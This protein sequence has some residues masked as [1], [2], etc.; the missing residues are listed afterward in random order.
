VDFGYPCNGTSNNCFGNINYDNNTSNTGN[1]I[2]ITTDGT[3]NILLLLLMV[4][5]ND[6]V[7]SKSYTIII[8]NGSTSSTPSSTS[9]TISP[10][11]YQLL[12]GNPNNLY[13]LYS[14]GTLPTGSH[15][16]V[17][18][19]NPSITS[20]G[21]FSTGDCSSGGGIYDVIMS[22][23]TANTGNSIDISSSYKANT[24]CGGLIVNLY[25]NDIVSKTYNYTFTGTSTISG[26]RTLCPYSHDTWTCP[27][28]ETINNFT[29]A[30]ELNTAIIS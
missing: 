18:K 27:K 13:Q 28:G 26:S 14:S 3:S 23:D 6:T 8:S 12:I 15:S 7:N 10:G 16:T 5:N 11:S 19:A 29:V 24:S 20:D 4:A 25:N 30:P 1:T 9:F 22:A 17:I 21:L 2:N